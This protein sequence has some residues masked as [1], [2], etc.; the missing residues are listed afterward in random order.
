[1]VIVEPN[2]WGSDNNNIKAKSV[3]RIVPFN[4]VA[5]EKIST[6]AVL[7]LYAQSKGNI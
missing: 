1:M 3:N 5:S 6:I 2:L 7:G 4:N